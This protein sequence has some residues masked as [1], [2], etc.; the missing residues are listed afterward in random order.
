[1]N[2][3]QNCQERLKRIRERW[4]RTVYDISNHGKWDADLE[5]M[6]GLL[7]LT[8]AEHHRDAEAMDSLDDGKATGAPR[9]LRAD[10]QRENPS[11]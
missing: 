1:M 8:K 6:D 3:E 11:E 9:R 10:V 2:A 5:A 7:G 4:L